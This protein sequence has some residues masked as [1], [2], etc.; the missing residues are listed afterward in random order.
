MKIIRHI[1]EKVDKE[2]RI[3]YDEWKKKGEWLW[4]Y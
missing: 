2:T 3:C 1:K 4:N